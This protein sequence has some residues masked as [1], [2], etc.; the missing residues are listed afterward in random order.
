[1]SLT[2]LTKVYH[3]FPHP[4]EPPTVDPRALQ[5]CKSGISD[6]H[7]SHLPSRSSLPLRSASESLHHPVSES[8]IESGQFAP[9]SIY[10]DTEQQS[11]LHEF[12]HYNEPSAIFDVST[13][14]TIG[15]NSTKRKMTDGK[16]NAVQCEPQS[17]MSGS[18]IASKISNIGKHGKNRLSP[19]FLKSK[20][21]E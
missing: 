18:S 3:S 19:T 13:N 10:G 11:L 16:R 21:K 14:A 4:Q 8:S 15:V 1:M 2:M 5:T 12:G 20:S 17:K 7:L 6:I 9:H